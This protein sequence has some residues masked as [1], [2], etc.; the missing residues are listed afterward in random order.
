MAGARSPAQQVRGKSSQSWGRAGQQERPGGGSQDSR[1]GRREQREGCRQLSRLPPA[2]PE[3]EVRAAAAAL[4]GGEVTGLRTPR[5]WLGLR[6][7]GALR[8]A[9]LQLRRSAP[10]LGALPGSTR[11]AC[12]M[13]PRE[14][15]SCL[16]I[17]MRHHV[18]RRGESREDM[19]APGAQAGL[20]EPGLG[21]REPGWGRGGAGPP[22][23]RGREASAGPGCVGGEAS[24]EEA[25]EFPRPG[26]GVGVGYARR[27]SLGCRNS[28][29]SVE[30][31]R[32]L[33]LLL[34]VDQKS[35]G[36][37]AALRWLA[38]GGNPNLTAAPA[39][40]FA[41][42][43]RTGWKALCR[44]SAAPGFPRACRRPAFPLGC[45][46]LSLLR[47]AGGSGEK[48]SC[49][50]AGVLAPRRRGAERPATCLR[51]AFRKGHPA[52]PHENWIEVQE[53]EGHSGYSSVTGLS[54]CPLSSSH[55]PIPTNRLSR[56]AHR[57]KA[58]S[59]LC[60]GWTAWR[61]YDNPNCDS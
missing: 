50:A 25:L 43:R 21:G 4:G 39:Q 42:A 27:P 46:V 23:G 22:G 13:L 30:T 2:P 36:M 5:S 12:L 54:C 18:N 19:R 58:Y 3:A 16:E 1:L 37:C 8:A 26:S 17:R 61:C 35:A 6:G 7:P 56:Q 15:R 34:R 49:W 38:E 10:P 44:C 29:E 48:R 40:G 20:L 53:L 52:R 55:L 45:L 9:Q 41:P 31:P 24:S 32:G 11:R 60:L 59:G 33:R 28:A 57:G 51:K 14:L 47:R